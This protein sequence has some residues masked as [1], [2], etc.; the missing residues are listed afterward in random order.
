MKK[1]M[2]YASLFLM[3]AIAVLSS[4]SKKNDP[5]PDSNPNAKVFETKMYATNYGSTGDAIVVGTVST[6]DTT[7]KLRLN[8]NHTGTNNLSKIF[9]MKSVDNGAFTPLISPNV[10]AITNSYG[11]FAVNSSYTFDVP[12]GTKSFILDLPVAVRT[13]AATTATDVYQ[14]W[15]T[16]GAGAFSKPGKNRV[17]GLATITLKYSEAAS[18]STFATATVDVGS[19]SSADYGSFIV[20]SGQVSSLITS[21]YNDSP[22]SADIRFV[23]LNGS[24]KKDNTTSTIYFY[25]PA[26]VG[27]A[28]PA[29]DGSAD[30]TVFTNSDPLL[31]S[32]TTKLNVYSGGT[33]FDN[34]TAATLSALSVSSG[35]NVALTVGS[36]YAFQTQDG[37][38]GL[39]K[40]NTTGSGNPVSGQTSARNANVTIKVQN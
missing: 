17:L 5:T 2:N 19:Q 18:S 9:I 11:T 32:R 8:V 3:T 6:T 20:T 22:G 34:V 15:V 37:K 33:S 28:N 16:D 10:S 29:G 30:F 24:G 26:N 1:L 38:K 27:D 12:S 40:V 7:V 4:C 35:T 39:I 21:D 31:A 23:T 13:S 36:V 25:S 14:I